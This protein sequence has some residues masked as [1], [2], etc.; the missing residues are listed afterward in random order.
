MLESQVGG[1]SGKSK[2][3]VKRCYLETMD[4]QLLNFKEVAV[5]AM[6]DGTL[7]R[8]LTLSP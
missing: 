6:Q 3:E 8:N 2:S 7:E 4:H 5:L 1:G